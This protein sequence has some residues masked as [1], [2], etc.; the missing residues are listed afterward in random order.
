MTFFNKEQLEAQ[1][2]QINERT[3]KD[4]F[5]IWKHYQTF[6]LP[7]LNFRGGEKIYWGAEHRGNPKLP[8]KTEIPNNTSYPYGVLIGTTF[9]HEH[10]QLE[11]GDTRLAQELYEFLT[12]G[13]M[14][15]QGKGY[16]NLVLCRPGEKTLVRTDESMTLY[17][18]SEK[19]LQTLD[20][21]NPEKNSASKKLQQKIGPPMLIW[22]TNYE[23]T[24]RTNREYRERGL[25]TGW[26]SS[27]TIRSNET[28]E[29]LFELICAQRHEFAEAG[30]NLIFG[31]NIPEALQEDFSKPLE[32][33]V[34]EKNHRLYNALGMPI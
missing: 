18:M 27:V 29:K 22:K 26:K 28:E 24:F 34:T 21:A 15:L 32:Q 23:L 20:Y 31:G 3:L 10:T 4:I 13:A 2:Y 6:G 9:G 7:P 12:Y 16:A 30:I 1:G 17:N 11:T 19:P 8:N 33:L 14:L 5:E 25:F